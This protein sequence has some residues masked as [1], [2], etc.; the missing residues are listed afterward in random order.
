MCTWITEKAAIMGHGKGTSDWIPL[1]EANVYYDHPASAPLNH[2]LIIDFANAAA[3]PSARVSVE[4]SQESAHA[5]V[6]AIQAALASGEA[7]HDRAT[8]VAAR[9]QRRT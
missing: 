9:Y 2:A 8:A 7:A 4:L 3:G 1:T 6:R 5:L